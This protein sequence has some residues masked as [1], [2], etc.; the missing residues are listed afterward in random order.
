MPLM[1]IYYNTT[2]SNPRMRKSKNKR[3]REANLE[4]EEWLKSRGLHSSQLKSS[5]KEYKLELNRK[6]PYFTNH[7]I[8][9][10]TTKVSENVYTG[11]L[12]KGIAT[13]HKSNAIPIINEKQAVEISKMRRGEKADY[14]MFI[15]DSL[16]QNRFLRT[17]RVEILP[18]MFV[19]HIIRWDT[20][21]EHLKNPVKLE[22]FHFPKD[23]TNNFK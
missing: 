6:E 8:T 2:N 18:K 17:H 20:P 21:K 12:I 14:T 5:S 13:M 4:H 23:F 15:I 9:G 7:N 10:K 16:I 11:T 1:P 19:T 3:I 22:E